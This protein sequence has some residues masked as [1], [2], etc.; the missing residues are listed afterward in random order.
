MRI[1][2]YHR[3][4]TA[5]QGASGLGLE[6]QTKAIEDYAKAKD[7]I[8]VDSFTEVESGKTSDRPELT[9][10]LHLA[11][12]T[13]TF[14]VDE[15]LS[16]QSHDV[17]LRY[18]LA[19]PNRQRAVFIGPALQRLV[20]KQVARHRADAVENRLMTDAVFDETLDE[21]LARARGR[22]ANSLYAAPLVAHTGNQLAKRSM[23][24]WRVRSKCIGVTETYPCW[25]A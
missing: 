19:V 4:S 22:H 14:A 17:R 7:A 24:S 6:A 10:A 25:I 15:G 3:V 5:R 12:V 23:A 21:P 13:G 11:K 9:K 8:L 1:V 18:R 16:H 2:A 20:D